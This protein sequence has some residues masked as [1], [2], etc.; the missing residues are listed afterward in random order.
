MSK[1]F[2]ATIKELV[3]KY[4]PDYQEQLDLSDL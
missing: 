1:P 4:L 2:D 3:E